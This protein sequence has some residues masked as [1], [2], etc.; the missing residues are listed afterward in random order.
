VGD[1]WTDTHVG[2]RVAPAIGEVF[3]SVGVEVPQAAGEL[4]GPER[5]L[6]CRRQPTD[7]RRICG[8]TGGQ[9]TCASSIFKPPTPRNRECRWPLCLPSVRESRDREASPNDFRGKRLPPTTV[10]Y[11]IMTGRGTAGNT[12]HPARPHLALSDVP[13][14]SDSTF[15]R[16][17]SASSA[18]G[19][20]SLDS[21]PGSR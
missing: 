17:S 18:P 2:S 6:D 20:Q 10:R 4:A 1:Y 21:R 15:L 11:L 5:R 12:E 8:R 13:S 7:T 9:P 3:G 14:L 19:R 16:I